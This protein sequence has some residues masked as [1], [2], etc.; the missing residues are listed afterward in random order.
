MDEASLAFTKKWPTFD[1]MKFWNEALGQVRLTTGGVESVLILMAR[2]P[3][4][5]KVSVTVQV[6]I[7]LPLRLLNV[8]FWKDWF[9]ELQ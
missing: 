4:F 3:E 2:W 7:P 1:R 9:V 5:P 8:V 6:A